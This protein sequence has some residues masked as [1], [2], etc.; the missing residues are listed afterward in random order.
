MTQQCSQCGRV[1]DDVVFLTT[2]PHNPVGG[3]NYCRKHDLFDCPLH[4]ACPKIEK[5]PL[6]YRIGR[7]FSN[8]FLGGRF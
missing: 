1:Y 7:W 2:C 4:G 6:R 5:T 3:G 8:K